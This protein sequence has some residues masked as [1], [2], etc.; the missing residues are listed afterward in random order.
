MTDK[1]L[2]FSSTYDEYR[3]TNQV[4]RVVRGYGRKRGKGV[5]VSALEVV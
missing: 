2:D 5:Q 3:P 1:T 4:R